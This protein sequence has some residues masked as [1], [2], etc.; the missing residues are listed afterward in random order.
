MNS[1]LLVVE[2]EEV[3]DVQMGIKCMQ[4]CNAL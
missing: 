3:E 1:G 2:V 4:S